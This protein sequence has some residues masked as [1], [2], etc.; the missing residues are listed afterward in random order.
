M[1]LQVSPPSLSHREE[2]PLSTSLTMKLLACRVLSRWL[3][4]H[5]GSSPLPPFHCKA[6]CVKFGGAVCSLRFLPG[7][8]VIQVSVCKLCLFEASL[9]HLELTLTQE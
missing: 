7:F 9:H 6:G 3:S 8:C 5:T 1:K 2:P 4:R